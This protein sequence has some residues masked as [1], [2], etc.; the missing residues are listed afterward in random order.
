MYIYHPLN[1]ERK[2]EILFIK[3]RAT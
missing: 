3:H 1:D 2:K